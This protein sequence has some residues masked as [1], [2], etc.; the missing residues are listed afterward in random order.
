MRQQGASRP[1]HPTRDQSRDIVE[2]LRSSLDGS[3]C[4]SRKSD[5][6]MHVDAV[7]SMMDREAE[8]REE[9]SRL[10]NKV[11]ELQTLMAAQRYHCS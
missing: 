6:A 3:S 10:Q 2:C 8:L 1:G 4:L 9:T 7:H 11:T 5:N